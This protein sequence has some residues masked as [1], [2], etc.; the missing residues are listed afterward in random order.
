[1]PDETFKAATPL[2]D[3]IARA[4]DDLAAAIRAVAVA[5]DRNT[6]ALPAAAAIAQHFRFTAAADR[7]DVADHLERF[8]EGQPALK[9]TH[10]PA[11]EDAARLLRR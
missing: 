4:T 8:L 6:A 1:M 11:I 7:A 9:P 5:V 3:A 10:R 2:T